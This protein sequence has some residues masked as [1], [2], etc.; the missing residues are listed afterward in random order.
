MGDLIAFEGFLNAST[1]FSWGEHDYLWKSDRHYHDFAPGNSENVSC[2]YPKFWGENGYPV[3]ND[4]LDQENGCRDSEFDQYGDIKGVGAYPSWQ[5]QLS[6]FASVQDRLRIWQQDVLDKLNVMSCMQISMLDID[7][8]RMDKGLQTP[9]D[10]QANFANYQRECARA[11]GKENFLIV[12]EVVGEIPLAAVYVG[13]GKQPDMK[14][15]NVTAAQLSN[16]Q[17]SLTNSSAYLRDF[18]SSAL[19]GA[20]F[21]YPTY[22]AMTRFLGLDGPIGFEGVDWVDHWSK[23]MQTDDM[24]NANT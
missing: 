11:H 7:G 22:G 16:A 17:S 1:P 20:A 23:L 2:Q 8:F 13:R 4:I 3:G 6:K 10:A 15:E 24:V 21:H 9:V 19:D 5:S 14:T 18:G 12:G